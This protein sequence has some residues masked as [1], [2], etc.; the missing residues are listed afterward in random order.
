MKLV[1]CLIAALFVLPA[2]PKEQKRS[3]GAHEHGAGTL[4]I[5]MEGA[6]GKFEWEIP[7]ESLTG[8]EHQA[9]TPAD[10]K[11]VASA[12]ATIRTRF[13]QMLL[14]PAASGCAVTV[15][16]VEVEQHGNHSEMHTHGAISCKTAIAGDISFAFGKVFPGIHKLKVQFVSDAVQT[17]AEIEHDRGALRIGK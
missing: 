3:A 14:L 4:N 5:A 6:K 8:F 7:M 10:K 9:K 11:K 12:Q 2:Q 16:D 15:A 1:T 17:G 13:S